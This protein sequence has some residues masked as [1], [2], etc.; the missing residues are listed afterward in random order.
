MQQRLE[1]QMLFQAS[2]QSFDALITPTTMTPAVL[3][4]T[5]N[6]SDTPAHFTRA[7]NYL[8]MCGLTLPMGLTDEGLPGG[9]QLMAPAYCEAR[10]LQI[11]AAF[12]RVAPIIGAPP[13]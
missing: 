10:V 4:A 7:A 3:V 13:T 2:L 8:G 11:G 5:I 12:E 6:Q 1:D 9:L